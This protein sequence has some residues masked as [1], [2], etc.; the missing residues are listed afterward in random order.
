MYQSHNYQQICSLWKCVLGVVAVVLML[1]AG[2]TFTQA[3]KIP[4]PE[5]I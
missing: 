1:G 2:A 3:F 5:F 4:I